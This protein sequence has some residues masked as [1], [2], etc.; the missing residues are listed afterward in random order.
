[1]DDFLRFIIEFLVITMSFT[2]IMTVSFTVTCSLV[3]VATDVITMKEHIG[4]CTIA[5][6][7]AAYLYWRVSQ[8]ITQQLVK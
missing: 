2:L 5:S 1:M 3:Y 7:I 8:E 4:E 6:P